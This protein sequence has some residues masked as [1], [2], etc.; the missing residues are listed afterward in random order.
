MDNIYADII[1]ASELA[2][3]SFCVYSSNGH[4]QDALNDCALFLRS[5]LEV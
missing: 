3:K 5:L 2:C 1:M 4:D